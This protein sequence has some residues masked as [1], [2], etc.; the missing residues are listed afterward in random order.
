MTATKRLNPALAGAALALGTRGAGRGD[1][2]RRGRGRPAG[3]GRAGRR[4]GAAGHERARRRPRG[5]RPGQGGAGGVGPDRRTAA[6]V[7]ENS[8]V[9]VAEAGNDSVKDIATI[10]LEVKSGQPVL[11]PGRRA[12]SLIQG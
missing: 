6:P 11:G 10:R 7:R 5:H 12:T 1:L 4:E 9:D 3:R 8:L 2:G